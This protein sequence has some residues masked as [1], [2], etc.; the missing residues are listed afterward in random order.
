M[1]IL[2]FYQYFATPKG[3]WGTRVYEFAKRW[4][5]E[6]HEV[7]V[8]SSI[9][10]KSDLRAKHFIETQYHDGIKV[11]VVNVCI[12]N[13]H[14]FILRVL[15]FIIYAL[16]STFYAICRKPDITIASSGPITVGIPGLLSKWLRGTKLVFEIRDL[17]PEGA[18]ELG[19][20]RNK[21]LI[22]FSKWFEKTLYR[23]AQLVVGLS[24][25]MRDYVVHNFNHP[26]V[27]SITNSANLRLFGTQQKINSED[28]IFHRKYAIYSG[29]IGEVN[30][31][32]WLLNACRELKKMNREDIAILMI[33]DGQQREE[34]CEL[35]N[36]EKLNS[37]VYRGLMP[38]NQ[39][40]A[41]V[42]NSLVSLV[43]L[44]GAPVLD[45][46]S[47][48]KFFE[49][50]AAGVPII[51]NTNGWMKKYLEEYHVGYTLSPDD[52]IGLAHKLIEL[53][54]NPDITMNM[55]SRA[56]DCAKRDFNQEVLSAQYLEFLC[57]L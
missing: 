52:S 26:N 3:S 2:I 4:V 19:I 18:I 5:D 30:N 16:V 22:S 46:S 33:G 17:W 14:P 47:P 51:Q 57:D 54:D 13:K 53:A 55:Q 7:E 1:K 11:N 42:Q 21:S 37:F 45:T 41:Y 43:P 49:S 25:G 12:D 6:G 23:N 31:S 10:S 38:K 9:Y 20:L 36:R 56:R 29:N 8:V 35:A 39:L 24:P 40:V 48:N 50:L 44:K 27:I 32:Y 15:S 34:I 28:S